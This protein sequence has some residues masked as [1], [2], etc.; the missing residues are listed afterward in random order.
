M[1]DTN[2][3]ESEGGGYEERSWRAVNFP[4]LGPHD[5]VAFIFNEAED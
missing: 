3:P 1:Y 5:E 4:I 2:R